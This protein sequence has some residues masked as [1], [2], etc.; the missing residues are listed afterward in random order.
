M[1]RARQ[2]A[3][4]LDVVVEPEAEA[5]S[6]TGSLR[7]TCTRSFISSLHEAKLAA[8]REREPPRALRHDGY[9]GLPVSLVGATGTCRSYAVAKGETL[10]HGT[11]CA[12]KFEC[13]P[14]AGLR[15]PMFFALK[16][17]GALQYASGK[18]HVRVGQTLTC[19]RVAAFTTVRPL[20]L[21]RVDVGML[22]NEARRAP[23]PPSGVL[24]RVCFQFPSP[25]ASVPR[26]GC[27]ERSN[28]RANLACRKQSVRA[29]MCA[30]RAFNTTRPASALLQ[31]GPDAA[32]APVALGRPCSSA[33]TQCKPVPA[34]WPE[35]PCSKPESLP[36]WAQH[37]V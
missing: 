27:F 19:R 26:F 9:S 31:A 11:T 24:L 23:S 37:A 34:T 1:T 36:Q 2:A 3:Q 6:R 29:C 7:K 10:Y 32:P 13:E 14:S 25:C 8:A 18:Y 21:A 15:G 22:S 33:W 30:R 16:A 35:H 12:R 20:L 28:T 4:R 17:D 5:F